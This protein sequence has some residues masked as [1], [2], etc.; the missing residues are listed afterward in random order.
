MKIEFKKEIA[1]HSKID[2]IIGVAS[3]AF[4]L[5]V[6]LSLISY[7][8]EDPSFNTATGRQAVHNYVGIVGAYL[9]DLLLQFFGGGA[10]IIPAITLVYGGNRLLRREKTHRLIKLFGGLFMLLSFSTLLSL[11]SE[12]IYL[13]KGQGVLSGGFFGYTISNILIRYFS[14]AGAYIIASTILLI[15]I[16]ITT[17]FSISS[18]YIGIIEFLKSLFLKTQKHVD[19]L[20]KRELKP[21]PNDLPTEGPTISDSSQLQTPVQQARPVSLE[22]IQ[23]ELGFS[24]TG[25]FNL[26]PL[27]ILRE[28]STVKRRVSKEELLMSSSILEKKLQDFGIEGRVIQVHPGPV[29]TMYEFEPAPGIKVN[30]IVGLADDIAMAMRAVSVRVVA[31]IPGKGAVGIEIPNNQREEVFLKEILSSDEFMK[32]QSPLTVALGKDIFGNP[33]VTA[34]AKMPHLLVAGAT[35]S[36]KSV[37]INAMVCSI[38][39]NT[40]PDEVRMLMIDPKLLELSVYEDIPHLL[41][42]VITNPKRASDAIKKVVWEME[43]RY[44]ILAEREV[45]NIEGYNRLLDVEKLPYILVFIDELADLMTI[46]AHEVEDS[47]ARLAQMA[48]AAGIHLVVATQR[49]SVDVLTGTIKANFPARISFQVSSKTDSR[50]I[51]DSIGAEQLLG[52]GDMLFLPPGTS[53]ITRIHGA[54]VSE[55]EI[56]ELVDFLKGQ[57]RPDYETFMEHELTAEEERKSDDE[58]DELYARAVEL[59]TSTGN[60]SISMIQRRL[61]VG[62][63]RAARMIEMMEEDGIVTPSEGGKPREVIRRRDKKKW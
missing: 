62:Y 26:P 10:Y 5:I 4:T 23:Q 49:P 32:S 35:G 9:S 29:V 56:K 17:R 21:K 50:T 27:S 46:S 53:R 33:V 54:Y 48:R 55:S 6:I 43:R 13:F 61:R 45:R 38:L 42:P 57:A 2:E 37:A 11:R 34:L 47:I 12:H 18:F 51:L 39:F 1:Q 59:V 25:V 7:D 44:K 28:P 36:G 52:K 20:S 8:H 40:R 16:L 31:P 63:N 24:E 22:P 41:H 30:R 19:I 15:S 58:R 3:I 14:T 60:A